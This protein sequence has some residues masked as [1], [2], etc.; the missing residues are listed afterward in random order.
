MIQGH[1]GNIF[2]VAEQLGC[3]PEEI[4][5]LSSNINPLGTLPGL[6]E[7]LREHLDRIR[8]LPEADGRSAIRGVAAL[9]GIAEER[10]LAGGGTTQFIYAA[11]AALNCR[12]VL[13][14]GPT[15]ADYADGCRMHGLEP[16]FF[17]AT[18]ATGFV[19]DPERLE[20]TLGGYDTVFLCNPN[21]PTGQLIPHNALLSLCRRFPAVRFIID[22]SYLPFVASEE[23]KGMGH[24]GLDNVLVL[25]SVSK[26]FGMPGLRAG[27]LIANPVLLEGFRRY[28]Q[29]WSVNSLAQ[30]AVRFLGANVDEATAFIARTHGYLA[31]EGRLLRDRMRLARLTLY[32]SETS[33]FL[34][35]LPKPLEAEVVCQALAR[36]R[37]LIRN[38]SNF[39]GLDTGYIRIALKDPSTNEIVAGYLL[40]LVGSGSDRA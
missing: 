14:V 18:A 5:D 38:C 17:L 34:M 30:E 9:L 12:K 26:I 6:L 22:E 33:Y 24:C 2:A 23:G 25:W 8:V 13:I 32:P 10:I 1:G 27:F 29:P 21:N 39:H 15:Y 3:R 35:A 7:H 40:D 20:A 36:Q 28:M 11:C 16:D 31:G 4:V 19:L 37:Y